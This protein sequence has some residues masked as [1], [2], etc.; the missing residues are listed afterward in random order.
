MST[1]RRL[2]NILDSY[3]DTRGWERIEVQ[4]T[5]FEEIDRWCRE[6]VGLEGVDWRLL[7]S[8]PDLKRD[9]TRG[10]AMICSY[11]IRERDKAMLF[12]LT[13]GGS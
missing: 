9:I 12:K 10:F 4:T 13:W 6:H 7:D 2:D 1:K 3:L 11:G 8:R 5:A